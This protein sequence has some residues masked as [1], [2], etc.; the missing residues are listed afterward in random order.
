M[1][2]TLYIP[3]NSILHRLDP[4]TKMIWM[5]CAMVSVFI[6]S[7][8]LVPLVVIAV[9]VAFLLVAVQGKLFENA[10]VRFLPIV[11]LTVTITHGFVNPVGKTPIMIGADPIQLPYFGMMKWEGL[12]YGV[13]LALRISA[14]FFASITLV[15]TTTPEDLVTAINKLGVP[16]SYASMFGM[17]L[18]MIPI[19]QEEARIIVQAQRARALRENNL[20]EKIQALVPLFVPLA[21]GSMQRTE[22]TAMVLEARAFGAPVKRTELHMIKFNTIDYFLIAVFILFIVFLVVLRVVYGDLSWMYSVRSFLGLFWP[23]HL[24]K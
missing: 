7:N 14:V 18:Q 22:T 6:L 16:Y 21:V 9:L 24:F 20:K 15:L 13:L 19:M 12:Y 23:V 5:V 2:T 17:S 3:G 11:I 8:P 1:K 10:L 4:R